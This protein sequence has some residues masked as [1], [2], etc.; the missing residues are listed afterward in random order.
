MLDRATHDSHM[1]RARIVA[2]PTTTVEPPQSERRPL[3]SGHVQWNLT[4][5]NSLG[6][7]LVQIELRELSHC[8]PKY[9]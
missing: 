6:P 1:S 4:N 3:Y 9:H 5:P 2:I 7:E 8:T